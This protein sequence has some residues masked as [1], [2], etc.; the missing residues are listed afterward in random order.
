MEDLKSFFAE[1]PDWLYLGGHFGSLTLFNED[2]YKSRAGAV[3]IEFA[4]DHVEIKIDTTTATLSRA[5][6]TFQLHKQVVAILWGGCSVCN[7]THTMKT[8]RNLFDQHVLLGFSVSTGVGM[9]DAMLGNDFIKKKHF[10]DNVSGRPAIM[11]P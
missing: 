2:S 8:L 4:D 3:D 6:D 9:V 5:D 1:T 7:T 11:T 10:F